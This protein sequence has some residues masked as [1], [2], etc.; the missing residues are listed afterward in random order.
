M[1]VRAVITFEVAP[2]HSFHRVT[3]IFSL[4]SSYNSETLH[5]RNQMICTNHTIWCNVADLSR[6]IIDG[7]INHLVQKNS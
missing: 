3:L 6:L 2:E 4:T 5:M 7:L 1:S